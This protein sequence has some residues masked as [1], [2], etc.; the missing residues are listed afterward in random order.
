M[1]SLIPG[2]SSLNSAPA[3]SRPTPEPAASSLTNAMAN[4]TLYTATPEHPPNYH[5][6]GPPNLPTRAQVPVPEAEVA[7][8]KALYRYDNP[9]DCRFEVGDIISVTKYMNAEWWFGRNTRTGVEGV[10]PVS[11]V[12]KLV[13]NNPMGLDDHRRYGAEKVGFGSPV[14]QN[15]FQ[16]PPYQQQG[17]G[18]QP[19]GAQNQNPYNNSVPP[20][21]VAAQPTDSK[22]GKGS[23]MGK[24]VGKKLGNAAIFGAGA[25]IG[26]NIV[27]SIF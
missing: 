8:A 6:T 1:M 22:T 18:Q 21:A 25:T 24:K 20:M 2:E 9:E 7:R 10:F 26:S 15:S 19:Y 3:T 4:T 23:E 13:E 17:Y 11:Y 5:S 12:E 16:Q 27:N 14:P